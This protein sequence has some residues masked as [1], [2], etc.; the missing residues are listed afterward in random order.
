M[1]KGKKGIPESY[2]P[3]FA[4]SSENMSSHRERIMG[5][6]RKFQIVYAGRTNLCQYS[7]T[8]LTRGIMTN[9][10]KKTA[11]SKARSLK[12]SKTTSSF[13]VF[14]LSPTSR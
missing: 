13:F 5:K 10:R 8:A 2:L 4:T 1:V 12:H 3:S 7:T 14:N 9:E 11:L 6:T